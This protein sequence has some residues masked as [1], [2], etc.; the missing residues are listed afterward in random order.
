MNNTKQ[1]VEGFV[2]IKDA[3][4]GEVILDKKNAIHFENLSLSTALVLSHQGYGHIDKLY[5]GNGASTTTGTGAVSYFPANTNGGEATL[6]NAT[7]TDKIV[8]GNSQLNPDPERNNIRVS[9]VDNQTY[10]DLIVSCL[11]D[12]NEPNGQ[13]AFDDARD[14]EGFFVFDEMGLVS[15]PENGTGEG[16]LLT[17]CIFHPVQKSVNRVFEIKYTVRIYMAE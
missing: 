14:N 9:H 4:T 6:Y 2:L 17:H 15:Y 8:D 16:K 12:S 13:E 7:Y 3:D 10:T 5:F 11:L 1:K